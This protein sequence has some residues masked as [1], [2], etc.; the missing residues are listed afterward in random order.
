MEKHEQQPDEQSA[1][2]DEEQEARMSA[3]PEDEQLSPDFWVEPE[4]AIEPEGPLDGTDW[5]EA[6]EPEPLPVGEAPERTLA[7]ESVLSVE[8][9]EPILT[10]L[11]GDV[12]LLFHRRMNVQLA[13]I[14]TAILVAAIGISGLI[15]YSLEQKRVLEQARSANFDLAVNTARYVSLYIDDTING[16]KTAMNAVSFKAMDDTQRTFSI[17]KIKNSN[18]QINNIYLTDTQGK[19]LVSTRGAIG[20]SSSSKTI[21]LKAGGDVSGES[22]FTDASAGKLVISDL[23]IDEQ[24][25]VPMIMVAQAVENVFDGKVGV[26]AYEIRMDKICKDFADLKLGDTGQVYMVDAVGK[27]MAFRDIEVV[28]AQTD[29]SKLDAVKAVLAGESLKRV[30]ADGKPMDDPGRT[31]VYQDLQG[32]KVLGGYVQLDKYG[33]GIV[34][35]QRYD[36]I[37]E[38]TRA[39]LMRLIISTIIFVIVSIA[40]STWVAQRFTRPII[41]MVGVADRI[42][43]GDL[44]VTLKQDSVNELGTL[45][46]AF[47]EMIGSLSD[48]IRNVHHSTNR[49]N[50]VSAELN[51]NADLTADATIHISGIIENVA[52]GTQAQI[53]SVHE[54][55]AAIAQMS[56]GLTSVASNSVTILSSAEK[57]SAM[58]VEG[59][60]NV[61][62]IVGI[63]ESINRIVMNTSDLV[64][65][66]NGHIGEINAIVD[67][68]KKISSQTN[69]LALNASIEAARAGEHGRGFAVVA[70]EVKNLADQSKEASEEIN[71]KITAIQMETHH[72]V[73][74]MAGGI[75]DIQKETRV[76]EETAD[77]FMRI[78]NETQSVA[79]DIRAFTESMQELT[80]GMGRVESSID[81]IMEVSQKNSAEAQNVLANVE[82][83]NAAVHHITESIEGLV[84]MAQ[85]LE[86]LVTKFKLKD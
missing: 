15:N 19:I 47:R 62:K 40:V 14:M 22:W 49:I 25:G 26:V 69:L 67:Y 41:G 17:Q 13:V 28:K 34:S 24:S 56:S 11:G 29:Y 68:I 64:V 35:E 18:I 2:R 43:H 63:M 71:R 39:A 60:G 75:Q 84:T 9:P 21:K 6:D 42:R 54:G 77:S 4:A 23:I 30:I 44:T 7:R 58:A 53:D 73:E 86:S 83:Q 20:T 81:T 32:Q 72:I 85:E 12:R 66:L 57:A 33:W 78:I 8:E 48:L 16:L 1:V 55:Q 10:G 45:Q 5:I 52:E 46:A 37:V 51:H 50:R 36:E 3:A 59:S 65:N 82:E 79:E 74:S 31:A 70:N 27:L 76:V 61:G 80:I 38:A